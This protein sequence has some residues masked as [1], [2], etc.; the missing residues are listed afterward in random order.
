MILNIPLITDL[1]QLQKRRQAL[2]DQRLIAANTKRFSY[3]YAIGDK[4]LK[5]VY[6]PGKLEP[7]AKGPYSITRVHANGTLSIQLAPGVIERIN[8]RRV[9]PYHE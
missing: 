1:Q 3:D 5:L 7:R 2:I 4:V 8:M 9:K 6:N